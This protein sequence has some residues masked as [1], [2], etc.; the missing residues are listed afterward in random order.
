MNA[1]YEW[2]KAFVP[3]DATP[4]QLR[5]LI[6]A[7][8]AT[9]DELVSV[10]QDLAPIVVA[11]VVE[12]S[13]HPDSDHLW[14][15]KV[16]DGSGELLEVVCGAPN[17]T[18]GKLYPF[19]R[20]GVTIPTG[21]KMERRKIRGIVSN[22]MLCSSK[23]LGLGSEH[24]GILEL[25]ID[26]APGTKFL[27]AMPVGDTR[28]VIDVGA[29]RSDLHSHLGL[30]REL[31]AVVGAPWTL[32]EIPGLPAAIASSATTSG[33]GTT[34][35]VS[36]Q[37]DADTKTRRYAACV[38]RGVKVGPSPEWLAKRVE[39][40][41]SR[42]INNVVDATN[43]VLHELG[44]PVHAFDLAKLSGG[45]VV[46]KATAGEKI[47]TLDGVDRILKTQNI[48]IADGARAQAV[49][50][51]MG[52]KD[53]EVTDATTDVLVEVA[54]F[55][56]AGTRISRRQLGLSTDASYRFERGVDPEGVPAALDRVARIIIAV[57]GGAVDGTPADVTGVAVPRHDITLR[58]ARVE[59]LLGEAISSDRCAQLL[60]AAGFEVTTVTDII[61][62]VRTPSWRT[63]VEKEVD[64]IEEIARFHG[65]DNFS[66]EIRPF[67][68]TTTHDD[69]MWVAARRIR[70]AMVGLGFLEAR[71]MPFVKGADDTHAP[72]ANPL[73]AEE[74]FLRTS[75]LET[76][77]RRAEYNLAQRIGDVRLFEIGAV[78]NRSGQAMPHEHTH[79][80]IVLMGLRRPPHFSEPRPPQLDEW[81][82]KA[83]AEAAAR[84]A[85]PGETITLVSGG[86]KRLWELRNQGSVVGWVTRMS[87]DAPVW[88]APAFGI[89]LVLGRVPTE[90]PAPHGRHNYME[91]GAAKVA[92]A[93]KY[94]PIP[95]MPPADFD[96]ALLVPSGT[97]VAQV[98]EKIR[99][100]AGELLEQ[101]ALFDQYVGDGVPAGHR[102][103]AWR[104]TF[105]HPERTLR[106]KEI[107]GRRAKIVRALEDELN[108]RQRTT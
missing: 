84:A 26:A 38:I 76:L 59:R 94:R 90:P 53:S 46:R 40:I 28:I 1:S 19:A 17:V 29:N 91:G 58:V 98:E 18:V 44:Q 31:S 35:G 78:F 30:A 10:R 72:V 92:Q 13:P 22:G 42:S 67:R 2:L 56:P 62:T 99:E 89:E 64:L 6:T 87:L 9:V 8:T 60:K 82:A 88:A 50:G 54:S 97:S 103:L 83:T 81:D 51:V 71:P 73:S 55:D 101:L 106:D 79:L 45:V 23:E 100:A 85:F 102:S 12:A 80:G 34:A 49:A 77:G 65:Y 47:T 48:V 11:R 21:M 96:L 74:A 75:V 15:T 86:D 36:I 52:G 41:G 69:P 24:D 66:D 105:R 104:L 43:Y 57:A 93:A 37:V 32:P 27:S 108:V 4:A 5:D 7:H 3:F 61:V 70:D 107:E 63:D 95:S 33:H 25:N 16:D 68:P 14:F 39:S 20:V